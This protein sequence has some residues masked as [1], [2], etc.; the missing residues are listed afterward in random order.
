MDIVN[1]FFITGGR[2]EKIHK[3]IFIV[4]QSIKEKF[5]LIYI[6]NSKFV[7]NIVILDLYTVRV[8]H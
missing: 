8:M 4:G 6:V 2:K 1:L 5:R 7:Y 3:L